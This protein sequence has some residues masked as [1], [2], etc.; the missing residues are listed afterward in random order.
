MIHKFLKHREYLL[1]LPWSRDMRRP[2]QSKIYH[3]MLLFILL[4]SLWYWFWM[5]AIAKHN[6]KQFNQP[7]IPIYIYW[8]IP[9]QSGAKYLCVFLDISNT[10]SV[11]QLH[12]AKLF[13]FW[14]LTNRIHQRKINFC[15]YS[16]CSPLRIMLHM[17]DNS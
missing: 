4:K 9:C 8:K 17:H 12:F 5:T 13:F 15:E 16:I 3:G 6:I 11:N 2:S 14:S 1:A 7:Q 10:S